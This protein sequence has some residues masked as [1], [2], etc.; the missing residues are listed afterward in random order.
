MWYNGGT[1]GKKA[2]PSP[3]S[4]QIQINFGEMDAG[5]KHL[6][7]AI[8]VNLRHL[9]ETI[10]INFGEMDAGTKHLPPAIRVNLRH[11]RETIRNPK[12]EI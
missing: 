7:P 5:T 8:R 1:S 6:P 2:A 4:R 3:S 10:R 9:R 11:L 12:S